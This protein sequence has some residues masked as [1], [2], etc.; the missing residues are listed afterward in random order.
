MIWH[1][2]ISRKI[3]R[4]SILGPILTAQKM[5]F[6]SLELMNKIFEFV[7]LC[8]LSLN[9]IKDKTALKF[10]F[11]NVQSDAGNMLNIILLAA[12][13]PLMDISWEK[14]GI[15]SIHFC[16]LFP[17]AELLLVWMPL[18]RLQAELAMFHETSQGLLQTLRG[19]FQV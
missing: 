4:F 9:Y 11:R 16:S 3:L 13:R 6:S 12:F 8:V 18:R 15:H 10:K 7:S 5:T 17:S 14:K 2:S 1:Q 19:P